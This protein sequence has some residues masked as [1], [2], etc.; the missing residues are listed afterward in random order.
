MI[1]QQEMAKLERETNW[2]TKGMVTKVQQLR[3]EEKRIIKDNESSLANEYE[4]TWKRKVS[5]LKT[6]YS[7]LFREMAQRQSLEVVDLQKNFDTH[8]DELPP[9]WSTDVLNLRQMEKNLASQRRFSEAHVVQRR[10]AKAQALDQLKYRSRL[11]REFQMKISNVTKQHQKEIDVLEARL[12]KDLNWALQV[13]NEQ[14]LKLT[15]RV[16]TVQGRLER[17]WG[18]IH[19]ATSCRAACMEALNAATRAAEEAHTNFKSI[20][21]VGAQMKSRPTSSSSVNGTK[22]DIQFQG[23]ESQFS[24]QARRSVKKLE[25]IEGEE[26]KYF[27]SPSTNYY[28]DYQHTK[29]NNNKN[30]RSLDRQSLLSGPRPQSF[31]HYK[32]NGNHIIDDE[33]ERQDRDGSLRGSRASQVAVNE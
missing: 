10:V 2:D 19:A 3:Q 22:T 17:H 20:S 1:V 12:E 23:D 31:I 28:D 32:L 29:S 24:P 11:A 15:A 16:R 14:L 5:E 7:S 25:D 21:G 8:R 4:I 9:K 13:R 27:G 33:T 30:H 18:S 6:Y 26:D